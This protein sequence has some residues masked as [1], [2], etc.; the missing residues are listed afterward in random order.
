MLTVVNRRTMS[1][2]IA[3]IRCAVTMCARTARSSVELNIHQ[4]LT[5]EAP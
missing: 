2:K 4:P 1:V 3:A 5:H